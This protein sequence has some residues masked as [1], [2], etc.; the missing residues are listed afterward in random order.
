MS[1]IDLETAINE[2]AASAARG[3]A[4]E[5]RRAN[6]D[7]WTEEEAAPDTGQRQALLSHRCLIRAGDAIKQLT[8]Q[9]VHDLNAAATESII[10]LIPTDTWQRTVEGAELKLSDYS[11]QVQLEYVL[12]AMILERCLESDPFAAEIVASGCD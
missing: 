1:T 8:G 4:P 12:S 9:F 7:A 11:R 5:V 6:R 2:A 3:F 10:G